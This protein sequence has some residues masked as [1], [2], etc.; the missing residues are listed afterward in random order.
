MEFV[1]RFDYGYAVPWVTQLDKERG[2]RAV[3]GPDMAVLRTPVKLRGE[4]LKTV[5]S[6]EVGAG[7][8]VPFVLT[9]QSSHMALAPATD[10][11]TA[12]RDTEAFWVRWCERC[13][14][15]GEW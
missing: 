10:V 7:E 11:E 1:L 14:V 2:I 8:S 5:A 9:Y 3:V 12:L 15:G 4:D 6:F 13:E